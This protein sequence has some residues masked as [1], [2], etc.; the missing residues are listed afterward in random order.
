MMQDDAAPLGELGTIFFM[1]KG[2]IV[3]PDPNKLKSPKPMSTGTQIL[4]NWKK[5]PGR[6]FKML[7]HYSSEP[8]YFVSVLPFGLDLG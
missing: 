1:V 6:T 5:K 4:T 8:L 3:Y 2:V 7:A